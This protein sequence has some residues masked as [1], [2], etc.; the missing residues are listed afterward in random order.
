MISSHFLHVR[1]ENQL[2]EFVQNHIK[3]NRGSLNFLRYVYF[4]LVNS[5]DLTH[6]IN[7]VEFNEIDHCLFE[8]FQNAFFSNYSLSFKSE[9]DFKDNQIVI[10]SENI[11]KYFEEGKKEEEIKFLFEF[12]PILLP[13]VLEIELNNRRELLFTEKQNKVIKQFK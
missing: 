5:I 9:I 2:F 1:S 8:H 10:F 13:N 3:G 12:Y 7:S 6:L 4:G 11:R